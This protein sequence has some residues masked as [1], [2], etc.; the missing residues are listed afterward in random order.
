MENLWHLS[1]YCSDFLIHY[2]R[3]LSGLIQAFHLQPLECA[4]SMHHL[5]FLPFLN[6]YNSSHHP[7]HTTWTPLDM[8][9][10]FHLFNYT[11]TLF[12]ATSPHAHNVWNKYGTVYLLPKL[13]SPT[14]VMPMS[15]CICAGSAPLCR[16][17]SAFSTWWILI[18]L[19]QVD[20]GIISLRNIST[21]SVNRCE[22]DPTSANWQF[23]QKNSQWLPVH[24]PWRFK[25]T[26][27]IDQSS[28]ISY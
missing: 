19:S 12:Q 22:E 24:V 2:S 26:Y 14:G 17:P 13:S 28:D 6:L 8:Q 18:H 25:I 11:I 10:T 15:P 3:H 27:A 23:L 21:T 5:L 16:E 4:E 7:K 1:Y 20:N 9:L